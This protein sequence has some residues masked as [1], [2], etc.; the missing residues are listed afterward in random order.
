MSA[1]AVTLG[2]RD[3]G[4]WRAALAVLR[5][6]AVA[7]LL[8]WVGPWLAPLALAVAA[9][10][11]RRVSLAVPRLSWDGAAWRLDGA[12]GRA[13]PALDLGGW[14]LIRFAPEAG[15][16]AWLPVSP[17][18]DPAAWGALRAALYSSAP[19]HRERPAAVRAP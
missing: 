13:E 11:W 9:W 4:A 3:G 12:A 1:A 15:A 10:S 5:G 19:S 8:A 16:I 6:L 7:A 18:A 14:M 2:C 17:A